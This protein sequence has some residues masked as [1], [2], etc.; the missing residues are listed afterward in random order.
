MNGMQGIIY[1]LRSDPELGQLIADRNTAAIPFGGRYRLID[2]ML[3]SMS[4]AGVRD[5]GVVMD[6]D[7]QS[8]LDHLSGGREWDLDRHTGGLRLLPPF[9]LPE[10]HGRFGGCMEALRGVRSY[11][12]AVK[13]DDIVLS[14]GD[15]AANIDLSAVQ[16]LHRETGAE[17]TAVCTDAA[18]L[19]SHHRLVPDGDG[20]ASKLLFSQSG[21]GEGLLSLEV[22]IIK[23][24]L[25]LS[26]MDWCASSGELHFH[27][28]GVAHYLKQ[29]GRIAIYRHEGFARRI[30]S[31]QDYY[32][33]S[34]ALLKPGAM[35]S[36]FPSAA[37]PIRTRE[38]ADASTY[39]SDTA[40]VSGSL[41]ADGCY[42]EGRVKN[43]VL[44]SGVRVEKGAE[45]ENCVVMHDCVVGRGASLRHVVADKNS[46]VGENITLAG[47]E[48]LPIIIPKGAHI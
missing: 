14:A 42:I 12:E 43:C 4:N 39:Y 23:K 34:M 44:F 37:R 28:S 2:F 48:R 20:F 8:L 6:R 32:D 1:S 21:P 29:G 10:S 11:I 46:A 33:A 30:C 16:A 24:T 47:N 22:Y 31:A 36:L 9:G 7:Y 13:H 41:V 26:L 15:L 18:P 27:R 19:Y 45:L 38:R 40:E 25:L 17:M 5:L 3:S 35:E